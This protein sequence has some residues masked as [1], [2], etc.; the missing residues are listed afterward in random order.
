MRI[1]DDQESIRGMG[2]ASPESQGYEVQVADNGLH[3]LNLTKGDSS[4]NLFAKV[5]SLIGEFPIR[6]SIRPSKEAE[7]WLVR[8]TEDSVVVTCRAAC[9]HHPLCR[10]STTTSG[11]KRLGSAAPPLCSSVQNR[12]PAVTCQRSS[13]SQG[14]YPV[15]RSL[16]AP[17]DSGRHSDTCV[18]YKLIAISLQAESIRR[19]APCTI[20]AT[21]SYSRLLSRA[22]RYRLRRNK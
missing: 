1:V 10:P 11:G 21:Y 20:Y 3:A 14:T 13:L 6:L 2:K 12:A 9:A 7:V 19:R 4:T 17:L 22:R 16:H 15:A 18:P 5:V 8:F